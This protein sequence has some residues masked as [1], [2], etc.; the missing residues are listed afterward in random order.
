MNLKRIGI[1]FLVLISILLIYTNRNLLFV[2]PL[3]KIAIENVV[4]VSKNA[5]NHLLI[6]DDSGRRLLKVEENQI[7]WMVKGTKDNFSEAKRVVSSENGTIFLQDIT[8]E[9]EGYR[10]CK[11]RILSYSSDGKFLKEI[12]VYEY[13]NAIL[14]P[15][16]VSIVPTKEG[17]IYTYKTE[18]SL[19]LYDQDGTQLNSFPLEGARQFVVSVALDVEENKIFYSTY[20]GEVYCYIDGTEDILLYDTKNGLD[21]QEGTGELSIPKEISIG[22]EHI[23]YV[24]DIGLRDILKIDAKGNVERIEEDLDLKDK[25]ISY[26]INA[27]YGLVVCSDYS[28][29]LLEQGEYSYLYSFSISQ[30]QIVLAILVWVAII[31]LV[32]LFII[33]M[34]KVFGYIIVSENKFIKLA[35]LLVLSI[36]FVLSIFLAIIF[37]KFQERVMDGVVSRAQLAAEIVVKQLPSKQFQNLNSADDFMG[38]DYLAVKNAINDI[39]LSGNDSIYD[40]YC[41]LYRI[42]DGMIVSTYAVQETIGAIYPYDWP[43]E[44]SDE[45]AIIETREGK[46]YSMQNS[47]GSYLF[48][49]NPIIDSNDEVIGLIEVGT[50]LNNFQQESRKMIYD[51]VI[52]MLAITVVMILVAIEVI[53]FWQAKEEYDIK[54]VNKTLKSSIQIPINILRM[55]VFLIFFLTNIATSFLPIYALK[56]ASSSQTFGIPV[57]VWAAI[58]I[59]AEV[60][61]GAVFSVFGNKLIKKLGQKRAVL[62]SGIVFT[63]GFS[64]RI[65]PNIWILILGNAIIG[66]GWGTLLLIINT[67]I[68]MKQEEEKDKGFA[69]YSASALN[70]VNSGVV[71]GSFLKNWFSYQWILI[72]ATILSVLVYFIVK[73][74]L[75]FEQVEEDQLMEETDSQRMSIWN[76]LLKGKIITFFLMIV[77][78]VIACGYFLNYMFPILA[79]EYGMLETNIGY[80]YLLNGLC[81]MCFSNVFTH[82]FSTKVSKQTALVYAVCLYAVAFLIV[83][84]YQS[85]VAL[86]VALML[87]GLS[88]CFGLPLQTGYY[89]DLEEVEQFGYDRAIGIYSLFENIAQSAGSF[90]FSYVLLIGVKEGLFLVAGTIVVLAMI[91]FLISL[92]RS[93]LKR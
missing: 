42:Q 88:D 38:E 46:V 90:I 41:M 50:D 28:V 12:A 22:T 10:I 70:G 58:P 13:E 81:V 31:I 57:E 48:I 85:I 63:I 56:L 14:A 59:S 8:K 87:L 91:F 47:E 17:V 44:N 52:N 6:L 33:G 25:E 75:T 67:T 65:I 78:P 93:S 51:L 30:A 69:S 89:T 7:K 27:D 9:E 92:R 43:Y 18:D 37:P 21:I 35:T 40:L 11:E 39:F 4:Y 77:I 15:Q 5:N 83:A 54:V 23:L 84:H 76:F 3:E 66:I 1:A 74:Y 26:Y 55:V 82:F 45:Q 16:I 36:L 60:I 68:A 24:A 53:L 29:K 79:S 2:N 20:K 80:S 71:I 49:L 86:L 61:T 34:V 72:F 73:K 64:L 19:E 62:F 32:S